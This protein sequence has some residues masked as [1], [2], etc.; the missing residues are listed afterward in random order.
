MSIKKIISALLLIAMLSMLFVGCGDNDNGASQTS[1][2]VDNI[3]STADVVFIDA[4]KESVYSIVRPENEY[5]TFTSRVFKQLKEKAGVVA[6]QLDDSSD[7]TDKYEIL[8]GETNRPETA[9]AKKYLIDNFG[10]RVGDFIVCTIDKKIVILGMSEMSTEKAVQYF[11]DNYV[12][13]DG[14]KGGILYTYSSSKDYT[15]AQINGVN[16]RN[17]SIIRPHFNSSYLTELEMRNLSEYIFNNF[18]YDVKILHD[19][20]VAPSEYEII[21]GNTSREGVKQLSDYDAYTIEIKGSKVYLNGGSSHA[22]AMAVSEFTKMLSGDVKDTVI[23][24]SYNTTVANYDEAKTLKPVWGDDFDGDVLDTSKWIQYTGTTDSAKGE[25]G[26]RSVRSGDPNDVF[27]SNGKFHICAREDENYYYGGKIISREKMTYKYGYVEMSAL[28]PHGSDFWVAL[29]ASRGG[30][31]STRTDI[32]SNTDPS[33]PFWLS[34]EIDIVEMFGNSAS[35]AANCHRWPTAYGNELGAKHTSL[36][37]KYSNEKKYYCP[38]NKLLGEDFHTYGMMWTTEA[39]TFVCDGDDY[40]TYTF[41]DTEEDKEAF[42]HEMHL[43][44][45]MA[46]GFE[47]SGASINDATPEQWQNT[48][49]FIVDWVHIYQKSDGLSHLTIY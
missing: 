13:A 29:W 42:H 9:T 22:T 49:K 8:V 24:G 32:P 15:D 45:S 39:M 25:N 30:S 17:F 40:F 12:K 27:V 11:L 1:S 44:I 21:V 2:N 43:I 23:N 10:G 3:F 46:L 47:S 14:I 31:N 6:K 35:Y 26:K 48:N 38:D 33:Q 5:M 41:Q 4:D 16:I 19:E 37:G 36:D 34:P 28:L 7:G 20:Y 18:G